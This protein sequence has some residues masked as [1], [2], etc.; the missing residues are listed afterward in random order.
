MA[1]STPVDDILE[2][3]RRNKF[4]NAEA[5]LRGEL[6]NRHDLNG[7][8][9]KLKLD[10]KESSGR[11]DEEVNGAK[12]LEQDTQLRSSQ[13]IARALKESSSAE[14]SKELIVKVVECEVESYGSEPQQ[15]GC[16][17]V[18]EQSMV[19]VSVGT[20]D[21]SFTFSKTSDDNVLDLWKYSTS[22]APS[23]SHQNDLLGF[24]VSSKALLSAGALECGEANLKPEEDINL[25]RERRMS[26]PVGT[27]KGGAEPKPEKIKKSEPREVDLR[28]KISGVSSKDCSLKTVFP[29]SEDDTLTSNVSASSA[30][31]KTE[32]KKKKDLN[33]IRVTVKDQVDE[34]GRALYLEKAHGSEPKGFSDLNFPLAPLSQRE[35]LPRLPPVR[36]KSE[37]K[38]FNI[39]WEEKHERDGL[40]PKILDTDNSYL[41]GSFLDVPI[42]QEIIDS[43]FFR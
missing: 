42:G 3:L 17:T 12:L 9:E 43:G 18:G 6:G 39:H 8:L 34:V 28:R 16:G 15:K 21:T 30:A 36:L 13:N 5:A 41:I 38:S 23:T 25:S 1:D 26:W 11:S 7:V 20:N 32:G 27:S 29:F 37:D 14:A 40:G 10:D 4:A 31:D 2:F 33:D 19:S 35:E 22:N 24:D